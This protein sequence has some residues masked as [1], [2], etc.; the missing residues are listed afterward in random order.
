M[1]ECGDPS[2]GQENE[3]GSRTTSLLTPISYCDCRR[4]QR[5]GSKA[6]DAFVNTSGTEG[7]LR[8]PTR[9]HERNL[10]PTLPACTGGEH[11]RGAKRQDILTAWTRPMDLKTS[12][13]ELHDLPPML[14]LT[15]SRPGYKEDI[16]PRSEEDKRSVNRRSEG[17]DGTR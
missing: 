12:V 15:M 11:G 3:T 2:I 1:L 5:V 4:L 7:C 16:T 13:Y 17:Q 8:S 14:A 9:L 6:V 10:F